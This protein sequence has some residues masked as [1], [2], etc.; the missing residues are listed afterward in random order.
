MPA[1]STSVN[2][3]PPAI[4]LPTTPPA[5]VDAMFPDPCPNLLP[6]KPPITAPAT[7]LF[8]P[9]VS[10]VLGLLADTTC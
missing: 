6:T 4:S 7:P 2:V 5:R 9:E 10:A 3:P 1:A 8:G